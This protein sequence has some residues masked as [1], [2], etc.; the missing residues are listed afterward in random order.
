MDCAVCHSVLDIPSNMHL[1][2]EKH[3][4]RATSDRRC[5]NPL[6]CSIV[7]KIRIHGVGL[8]LPCNH[9]SFASKR[10]PFLRIWSGP[11]PSRNRRETG[12]PLPS[13]A[14]SKVAH[15]RSPS[16][17]TRT[18]LRFSRSMGPIPIPRQAYTSARFLSAGFQSFR[19]N[20]IPRFLRYE[21]WKSSFGC[22]A[23]ASAAN[24]RKSP[25]R[26]A[27]SVRR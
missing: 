2:R 22:R 17:S 21:R 11:K 13:P 19:P 4:R 9:W 26:P 25:C 3:S 12:L 7:S 8:E 1:R 27:G 23:S 5:K 14:T 18:F 24:E 10:N 6:S 20:G 16:L 15:L